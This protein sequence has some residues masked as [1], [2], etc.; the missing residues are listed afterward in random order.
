MIIA[1]LINKIVPFG[2]YVGNWKIVHLSFTR[3]LFQN[4][5]VQRTVDSIHFLHMLPIGTKYISF[6]PAHFEIQ[7]IITCTAILCFERIKI[8][9]TR[10]N[11]QKQEVWL[12]N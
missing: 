11:K 7:E 10:K 6:A 4:Y 2:I 5:K 1:Y 3:A 12:V 9:K 8:I